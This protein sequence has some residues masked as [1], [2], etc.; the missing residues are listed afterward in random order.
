M[1]PNGVLLYQYLIQPSS[2]VPPAADGTRCR[3]SQ[4][5]IMQSENLSILS[6]RWAVFIKSFCSELRELHGRGVR[7]SVRARGDGR[8]Q[9]KKVL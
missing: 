5:H 3:D 8:D 2:K 1:N 7:K 4:P 9:E 6:S